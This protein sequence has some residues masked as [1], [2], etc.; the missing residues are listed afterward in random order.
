M[1]ACEIL[2]SDFCKSLFPKRVENSNKGTFGR[3]LNIA[4]SKSYCGAALLSSLSA[5]RVGCGYVTLASSSYVAGIS[6]ISPIAPCFETTCGR[7][8]LSA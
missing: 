1:D 5:L 2:K 4:G 3:V 7:K 6:C 8:E